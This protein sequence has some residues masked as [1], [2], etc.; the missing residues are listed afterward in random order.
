MDAR[1]A[2]NRG[3]RRTR[4]RALGPPQSTVGGTGDGLD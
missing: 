1:V 2:M 4:A 3:N